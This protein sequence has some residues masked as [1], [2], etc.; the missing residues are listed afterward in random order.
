MCLIQIY[1]PIQNIVSNKTY[2]L[3]WYIISPCSQ[4]NPGICIN[5]REYKKYSW[6]FCTSL[7]QSTQTENYCSFVLLD[8]LWQWNKLC[9]EKE[10]R[11]TNNLYGQF[12]L[13]Q[14]IKL[15][16]IVQATKHQDRN[17]RIFPHVDELGV[18]SSSAGEMGER[19]KKSLL[20]SLM[21][22]HQKVCFQ[23]I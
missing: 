17:M 12:T 18:T 10:N 4:I 5:A 20:I 9:Q 7:H 22:R 16:G 2:F 1:G 13:K 23:I 3:W 14:T 8:N 6:S 15:N 11:K 19:K 21:S